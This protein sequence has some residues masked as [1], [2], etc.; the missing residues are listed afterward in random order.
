MPLPDLSH[1]ARG[2]EPDIAVAMGDVLQKDLTIRGNSVF[3]MASYYAAVDFLRTHTVPLERII[4][5]R[6][7][8]DQAVEAFAIFNSGETGKVIF[9]W[10]E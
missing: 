5:H 10:D 3:T 9:E 2:P 6:F 4:T 7:T 8:I 1:L